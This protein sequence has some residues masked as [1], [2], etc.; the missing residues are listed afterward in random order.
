MGGELS[1]IGMVHFLQGQPAKHG[2]MLK[3]S[4]K[5]VNC[6]LIWL[7]SQCQNIR[8]YITLIIWAS[9]NK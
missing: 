7:V 9:C 2:E 3:S 8:K 4:G 5:I 6:A 1:E